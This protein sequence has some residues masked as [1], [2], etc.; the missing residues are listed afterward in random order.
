MTEEVHPLLAELKARKRTTYKF[1]VAH[2]LGLG[3]RPV[4]EVAIW[5]ATKTEQDAAVDQGTKR[6]KER[7]PNAG[8]DPDVLNDSKAASIIAS[9]VRDA[10]RPEKLPVF[11]TGEVLCDLCSPEQIGALLNLVLHVKEK[12]SPDPKPLDMDQVRALAQGCVDAAATDIPEMVLA[13]I[14]RVKLDQ[15]FVLLAGLWAEATKAAEAPPVP[16]V[17]DEPLPIESE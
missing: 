14:S 7:A 9:C 10:E 15:A 5:A 12:E 6:S 11:P 3:G 8:D 1:P 17:F 4:P 13:H 16:T 2:L